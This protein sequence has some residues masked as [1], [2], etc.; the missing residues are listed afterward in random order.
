MHA[1]SRRAVLGAGIAVASGGLLGACSPSGGGNGMDSSGLDGQAGPAAATPSE[2]ISPHGPEVRDREDRRGPGPVRRLQLTATATTLD[3]G[4]RQ[5]KSWAYEDQLPGQAIRVTAGET[6]ALTLVN[7]LPQPTTLHWHGIR[8]RNDMDG[9]PGITQPPIATGAAFDYRFT[10]INP[11]TYWIHPHAGVQL[12]R[13]LYAPMIV[14]DP[15]EPLKY[16]K[17]WIVVLDDW[18]DGVGGNTPDKVLARLNGGRPMAHGTDA[19]PM[20]HGTAARPPGQGPETA[21]SGMPPMSR[22]GGDPSPSPTRSAPSGLLTGAPSELLGGE[23][24]HVAYRYYLINGR[25]P[26]SPQVFRA[27]RGDRIRIRIINAGGDTAFRV[28]L[29]GHRMTVTHTDGYPVRHTTTD[30][31]LLGMGERYDVLVTAKSGVFPFA[32]LAEGKRRSTL[33]VLHTSGKGARKFKR[34]KELDGELVRADQLKAAESV[35]LEPRPPDRTL[36]LRLTGSMRKFDWAINDRPYEPTQRYPVREG[37][38]VR[39]TFINATEMWHPVHVHGHTYELPDGGPR[40]D[41]T[42]LLPHRKVSVDF[43]ADNPGL[44]MIH[45]HN[46]Y[47]SESGMMTVLGYQK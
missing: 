30:A 7:Q 29:G 39:L 34:P 2:Y 40:K 43:D 41:T 18:L 3:L 47:H 12:D 20:A 33:A 25:T 9:V 6:L 24:G 46:V 11:G 31:L 36:R 27:K 38:R 32:A 10:A 1:H 21:A 14:E 37:E 17:E 5:V 35:R 8:L 19:Q 16:D 28:A 15:R 45:C 22:P 4:A 13:G 26:D 23:A 44:W 42:I